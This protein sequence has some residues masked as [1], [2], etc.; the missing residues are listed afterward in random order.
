MQQ[1]PRPAWLSQWLV[2]LVNNTPRS[3]PPWLEYALMKSSWP[4]D[5]AVALLLFDYLAELRPVHRRSF[6]FTSGTRIDTELRGDLYSLREAW[7]K[8][9][10]P[11]LAVAAPDVIVI[12][13]RHLRRAHQMLTAAGAARPGWD[14]MCFSRSA[15]EPHA[16]DSMGEPTDVLIDAARDCLEALLNDGGDAGTG[17]LRMWAD[18][19]VPLLRRFAVHGWA[20]RRDV[21]ASAKLAW[22][23][24]RGWLFDHQLRHEV[25][26]LIASAA[27]A[28]DVGLA[29][30]L[31]ADAA[32]GPA[33]SSH[34]DYEAYNAL[35]WI[36]QHAPG[37]NSAREAL[38]QAQARHP[39]YQK[40]P[41]PD[42]MSWMETGW[43]QPRPPMSAG[44]LHRRIENDAADAIAELRRYEHVT[45]QF[46]GPSWE[47]ALNVLSDTV[48]DQP[49]D[50]FAV[51]D[52]DRGPGARIFHA[53]IRGWSA[54]T[55]DDAVTGRIIDR[56]SAAD[57]TPAVGEVASLL[58]DGGQSEAAP[59]E[60]HRL[61]A[62]RL[63]ADKVWTMIGG[64][65]SD[66]GTG[67]WPMR[68]LNHPAGQLAQFWV[69]A[70]AA[71]WQEAGDSWPGLPQ[72]IREQLEIMLA[73]DDDR[74][75]MAQVIFAS[76]VHFFYSADRD[77]CLRHVL[78]LLDWT[79][80]TRARRAWEGFLTWGQFDNQLLQTGLLTQYIEAG[81]RQSRGTCLAWPEG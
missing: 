72:A 74:V 52:A 22:L 11:N 78:P 57:I 61:P 71:D 4:E 59:T 32:A 33:G 44:E 76:K 30:A 19:D 14:P 49:A 3:G 21:D 34:R 12:A 63:L 25:F 10:V 45:T 43:V 75:A 39:E 6:T 38:S 80:P 64:T 70:A 62:A 13:D 53:V 56:L 29:D 77:W 37:L 58:A 7:T 68:A 41:H 9:F 73:G 17:Y 35:A 2:L 8:L 79:D 28:A 24:D 20:Y 16:Q 1:G 31:V 81:I 26:R 66:P 69:R 5:R 18:S 54:A 50:G 47:D 48:R 42:L 55:A 60:W 23:R 40:R 51:L 65:S 27:A 46:E 36:A 15:V 67:D